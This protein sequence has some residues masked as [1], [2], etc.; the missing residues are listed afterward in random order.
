MVCRSHHV[1]PCVAGQLQQ[2]VLCIASLFGMELP[3]QHVT[4]DLPISVIT[5]QGNA[6]SVSGVS[7][8]DRKAAI[9]HF[10]R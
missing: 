1:S 4:E 3:I 8:I 9:E 6:Y 2:F 5:V 10:G 7:V